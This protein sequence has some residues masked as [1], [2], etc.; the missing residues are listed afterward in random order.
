VTR[1]KG[2]LTPAQRHF[3]LMLRA[4]QSVA[5]SAA[6]DDVERAVY[7]RQMARSHR[8]A[9]IHAAMGG[10]VIKLRR[11]GLLTYG[12]GQGLALTDEGRKAIAP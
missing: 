4:V 9:A 12:A 5:P 6:W 2:S 7:G 1:R 11:L 8:R 3:L 10:H